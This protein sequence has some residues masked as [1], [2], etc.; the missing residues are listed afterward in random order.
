[1]CRKLEALLIVPIQRVPRYRLLLTE[2]ISHTDEEDSEHTILNAALNQVEM[3]ARHINEQIRDQE[4]MQRM[5]RIQKSLFHGKPKIVTPGRRFVREGNL[6]KVS[7]D[8]DST[9]ERYFIL[10]SDMLLYCKLR[11]SD[12]SQQGS[13]VCS[14]IL[15]LRHC[16]AEAVMGD[17]LFKVTC[18]EESILLCSRTADEGRQWVQ[19]INRAVQQLEAN[20]RTLRKESSARKPIRKQQLRRRHADSLSRIFHQRKNSEQKKTDNRDCDFEVEILRCDQEQAANIIVDEK[21]ET[22]ECNRAGSRSIKLPKWPGSCPGTPKFPYSPRKLLALKVMS[23]ASEV[24][25]VHFLV[26]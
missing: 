6:R 26:S 23:P 25:Q 15:P 17:G 2:L 12:L 13:L 21:N 11:N 1:M 18:K 5:I 9:H 19:D 14:C 24:Q 8:G 7:S 3:V 4:N 22:P 20:F 16:Q 10:F